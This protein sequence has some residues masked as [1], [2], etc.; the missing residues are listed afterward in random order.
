MKRVFLSL[1]GAFVLHVTLPAVGFAQSD[2]PADVP[3]Q[4]DDTAA[5]SVT[6]AP[7][8]GQAHATTTV[9]PHAATTA[10]EHELATEAAAAAA[11]ARI[12]Q[13]HPLRTP[14]L[15]EH[16]VDSILELFD[17]RS[18]GNT[19]VHYVVSILFLIAALLAR[20]I[21]TGIL[22]VQLKKLAAKTETTLD[23]K[24]FPAMEAPTAAFVMVTGIF[25][26]LK[27]LK[28]SENADTIIN[29]GSTVAFALVIFWGL[30]CA[31]NAVLDHAHEL[32]RDKQMGIA[33]FMPWIKKTLF[34]VFIVIGVLLTLK[35]LGYDVKALLA[36][37]GIGGLAFALAAQDTL[38]NVFGSIVVAIDQPFK[39]GEAVRIAGNVGTVEDIGLRSTRIRLADKSLMVLPNKTVAAE[40]ITNLSRFTRRRIEQVLGL[41]YDTT[42]EQMAAIVNELRDL[43][44][45]DADVEKNSVMVYFRDFSAS[46]LDLWVVYET[47]DADFQ[48]AMRLR[49]RL[50]LAIM[51]TITARGLS[52]AFPTQTIQLDGPV[53]KQLVDRKG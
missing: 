24:L 27:V 53:A 37:L 52:F 21:V 30:W 47:P 48:K 1:L 17:V 15:L 20:R 40:T 39:V 2:A 41:T 33:S 3:E 46:S 42:P 45:A 11:A 12:A 9:A 29:E 44:R 49:E 7:A 6:L 36:G 51:R 43:I 35:S 23:D 4:N 26:A 34:S 13:R 19:V 31:L 14:D 18:S 32:A 50:N 10:H 5:A 38:A 28:L 25:A 8:A 22:F 16:L